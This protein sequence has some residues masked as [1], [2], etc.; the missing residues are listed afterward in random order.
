MKKLALSL[1]VALAAAFTL[2][3]CATDGSARNP[4]RPSPGATAQKAPPATAKSAPAPAVTPPASTPAP[5]HQFLALGGTTNATTSV[6]SAS[7]ADDPIV[8]GVEEA[9]ARSFAVLNRTGGKV[10]FKLNNGKVKFELDDKQD[11]TLLIGRGVKTVLFQME[12]S[13]G[14]QVTPLAFDDN[15][16]AYSSLTLVPKKK[17]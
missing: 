11:K 8:I 17:P 14:T 7:N 15:T 9:G 4:F 1:V 6:S 12:S 10:S 16:P 5:V 2:V 3:G 13:E